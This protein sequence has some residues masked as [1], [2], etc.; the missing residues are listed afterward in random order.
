[1]ATVPSEDSEIDFT[2][3]GAADEFPT[4]FPILEKSD[5]RVELTLSGSDT[6]TLQVEG[7]DYEVDAAPS[8]NPT[9]T[10]T[11]PPPNLSTLHIERTLPITQEVNLQTQGPFSPATVTEML[12]KSAM[13]DQQ[14]H[15]RLR[16]VETAGTAGDI[17]A[18]A[19]VSFTGT[20]LNVNA[21]DGIV[22]GADDVSADFGVAGD[23]T[24]VTR[25]AA[26]A[27]ASGKVADAAHKHD[28]STAAAIEL[29]DSTNGE[30]NA[31]SLARSNHT[32]AHGVRGGGTLH[33]AAVAGGDAGFMSGVDKA[34]LD[35]LSVLAHARAIAVAGQVLAFGA[36][37]VL[38]NLATQVYDPAG[39]YNPGNSRFTAPETG[40]YRVD[41][42]LRA[43]A[44]VALAAGDSLALSVRKNGAT[45][46]HEGET[47]IA[48][49]AVGATLHSTM[50]CSFA[51]NQGDY[52]EILVSCGGSQN[53]TVSKA[54][55]SFDQLAGT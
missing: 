47:S 50:S 46:M 6:P 12:D 49:A 40:Y 35:V 43:A 27:G 1:M 20:T 18:G 36:G 22:V 25:A 15:R 33:A 38:L 26:V 31:T 52:I 8:A 24:A 16:A 10:M 32:H 53:L 48:W 7:V 42:M 51:L 13:I 9:V 28:V 21:G 30:G 2:G 39:A 55:A 17:V 14:L 45:L 11:V 19:G 23:M 4:G 29:T 5:L 37:S 3:D 41:V 54:Q 44:A 34:T